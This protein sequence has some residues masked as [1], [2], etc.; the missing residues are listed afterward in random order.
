MHTRTLSSRYG[1][2]TMKNVK[3]QWFSLSVFLSLGA[4]CGRLQ[5]HHGQ[6]QNKRSYIVSRPGTLVVMILNDHGSVSPEI[7]T[8]DN[9][10]Q[11]AWCSRA[12][13]KADNRT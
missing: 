3:S 6:L 1:F 2:K 9:G 10:K 4:I 7:P 8:G 12:P 13:H 5:P 11:L